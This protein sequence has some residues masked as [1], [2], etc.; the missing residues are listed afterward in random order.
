MVLLVIQIPMTRIWPAG[1][2]RTHIIRIR[3]AIAIYTAKA[4][5]IDLET[6][7]GEVGT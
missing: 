6:S 5:S 7:R 4:L 3:G 2:P 1:I